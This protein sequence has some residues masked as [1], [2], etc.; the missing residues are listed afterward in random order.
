VVALSSVA[1]A[2]PPLPIK[3]VPPEV[4]LVRPGGNAEIKAPPK[5]ETSKGP[6]I[7]APVPI[8]VVKGPQMPEPEMVRVR[9]NAPP[10]V[11]S[12]SKKTTAR[13]LIPSIKLNQPVPKPVVEEEAPRE[14][15][16]LGPGES[17]QESPVHP[18]KV[19]EKKV[20]P[21]QPPLEQKLPEKALEPVLP[22]VSPLVI[23]PP[24]GPVSETSPTLQP[25]VLLSKPASSE[26]VAPSR[27]PPLPV[28]KTLD[29]PSSTGVQV[30]PKKEA[31]WRVPCLL[32]SY[33]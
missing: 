31:A 4:K 9:S 18:V 32:P 16:I 1:K 15:I 19:V 7:G 33:R 25:P 30:V 12:G 26:P 6:V 13:L 10:M 24:V 28:P 17:I 21:P 27:P 8:P 3:Q 20:L 14:S 11:K 23:L 2:P 5:I 22:A 29:K